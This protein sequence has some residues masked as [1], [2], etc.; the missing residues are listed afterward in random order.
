MD[1]KSL[2]VW[3]PAIAAGIYIFERFT[4]F[5]R[6]M[7]RRVRRTPL[8]GSSQSM[9]DNALV[10]IQKPLDCSTWWQMGGLHGEP[11][12]LIVGEYSVTNSMERDIRL[13]KVKLKKPRSEGHVTVRD[14]ET[15]EWYGSVVPAGATADIDFLLWV[16][17][18][19]TEK[20]KRFRADVALVDQFNNEH[21]TKSVMFE[22]R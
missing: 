4:G 5:F 6:W 12:M 9:A 14:P 10:V 21:W 8:Q 11:A 7:Y 18:P 3:I 20:G 19:V 16:Q 2:L 1:S 22:Y 17:P 15:G 13:L